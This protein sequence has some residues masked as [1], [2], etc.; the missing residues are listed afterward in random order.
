MSDRSTLGI[1]WYRRWVVVATFVIFVVLAGVISKILPKVYSATSSLVVVQK[2]NAATFD[3]VQA[4]QVT[5]RTYSDIVSSPA[6]AAQVAHQLGHG[7]T[8]SSVSSAVSVS[9]VTETQLLKITAENHH[10]G[11]AQAL[12]NT[13][14][15]AVIEYIR[16]NVGPTV[17]ADVAL[18]SAATLPTSPTRPRPTLYVLVAAILGLFFGVGGAFLIERLDTGLRSAEEVRD[19]FDELILAR[20]PRRGRTET[21]VNAFNEAFGLLRTN[22]SF[23]SPDR[24]PKVIAVTSARE[25]EGKTTCVAQMALAMAEIDSRVVVVDADFR[26]PMLQ[27]LIM[28]E[29]LERLH[30]GFSNLLLGNCSLDEI[31]H[32][33]GTE[34]VELVPPGSLPASPPA[35]LESHRVQSALQE[36]AERTDLVLIDCPPLSAGADAAILAGQVDGVI[37]VVDLERSD[38]RAVREVLRQLQTV[39]A[40]VLGFVLNR[41]RS[42]EFAYDYERAGSTSVA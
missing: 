19:R 37:V 18:A 35:F 8:T 12:A 1:L 22:L 24:P 29:R 36:L 28:P 20:M 30:P 34:G 25:G 27:K 31:V 23:A 17:G 39:H 38:E 6:I 4:A 13:Y 15:S 32:P 42:I 3:A 41:D 2:E 26:R 5:A 33:T 21:S 14:A 10:A 16:Q 7:T 9:P 11:K 40:L